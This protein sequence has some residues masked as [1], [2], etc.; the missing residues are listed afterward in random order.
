MR[1]PIIWQHIYQKLHK[2]KESGKRASLVKLVSSLDPPMVSSLGPVDHEPPVK[3]FVA[4]SSGRQL[5][6]WIAVNKFNFE[7]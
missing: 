6:P 5:T 1:Q 3:H 7:T 4:G 2:K